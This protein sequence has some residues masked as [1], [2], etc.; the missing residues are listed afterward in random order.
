MKQMN[1][2]LWLCSWYP[3]PGDP[4]EGD[5]IQRH[6]RAVSAYI[7][8]TIFYMSQAGPGVSVKGECHIEQQT[9]DVRERIMFFRHQKTGI[10][11]IDTFL[12]NVRYFRAYKKAVREFMRKEGVP[13]IVHVHIPMKAGMIG[14][15]IKRKWKIPFIVSEHSAHYDSKS[16]DNFYSKSSFH[17]Y[18]VK[19]ILQEAAAVTNVSEAVG[20]TLKSLFSLNAVRVI[21]NTVNTAFFFYRR[22]AI[23]KFRFIHVSTLVS[24]Q[25]NVEG[26][27]NAVLLLNKQRQD[28]EIVIV[29]PAND[30]LKEKVA[31]TGLTQIIRLTGEITYPDVALEMQQASALVLFSRY[32]NL[33]CVVLEALCCGIPVI[34]SDTG[35]IKEAVSEANGIL[36]QSENEKQLAEAMNTLMNDYEKYDRQKIAIAATELYKYDTVGRKFYELY[37]EVLNGRIV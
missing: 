4:F 27:L 2:V 13:D 31:D 22:Q 37:K 7:P 32:E 16:D 18:N 8:L 20:K 34:S 6:A 23:Q 19:S 3:H 12:Y 11:P 24:H 26:I 15:W 21:P 10:S 36:V 28:F 5:F 35:G 30:M 29:G 14:R 1:K 9:D 25:K 33:P 17:R